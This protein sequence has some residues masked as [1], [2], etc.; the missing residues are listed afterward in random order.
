MGREIRHG[1]VVFGCTSLCDVRILQLRPTGKKNII[2]SRKEGSIGVCPQPF[3][4]GW[5]L[6]QPLAT[7]TSPLS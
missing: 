1:R 3:A 7:R 2:R 5:N 6:L 4:C